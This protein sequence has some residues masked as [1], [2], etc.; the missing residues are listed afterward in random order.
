MLF[1]EGNPRGNTPISIVLLWRMILKALTPRM[2]REL[3]LDGF[4]LIR[5]FGANPQAAHSS[6]PMHAALW[7]V[8]H[9]KLLIIMLKY[10]CFLCQLSQL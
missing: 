8:H 1:I 3:D 4:G 9:A 10:N 5:V 7:F 6:D 2:V